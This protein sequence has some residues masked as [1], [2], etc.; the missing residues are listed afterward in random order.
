MKNNVM[1]IGNLN[2]KFEKEIITA[3]SNETP[4]RIENLFFQFFNSSLQ[5]FARINPT[6]KP[7]NNNKTYNTLDNIIYLRKLVF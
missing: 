6:G 4:A 3:N 1:I 5:S 7:A 2:S